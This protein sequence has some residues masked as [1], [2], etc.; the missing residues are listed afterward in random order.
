MTL[1]IGLLL[2]LLYAWPAQAGLLL[3]ASRVIYPADARERSLEIV[4][5][6]TYPVLLQT[7]VD[8]GQ[9]NGE[10]SLGDSPFVALPAVLRLE[11]LA[12]QTI[13]LLYN[14]QPLPDDRESLYWLNLLEIPPSSA[15]QAP[16]EHL[17]VNLQTQIKVL[18]RPQGLGSPEQVGQRQHVALAPAGNAL[19]WHN[20]TAH[21][22]TL[23][24][25]SLRT[26]HGLQTLP[27]TLLAPFTSTCIGL[28][29][30]A[31]SSS[32]VEM[33]LV[34]DRGAL[35]ELQPSLQPFSDTPNLAP[36]PLPAPIS[37][38]SP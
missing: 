5:T 7:W 33:R 16:G 25:V 28:A 10:S 15:P 32:H 21:Y 19:L 12:R 27:G 20:P 22:V 35:R 31:D 4:N 14:G 37:D 13:R 11:P 38:A 9:H 6:N 34:D 18:W 23:S 8:E 29:A 2:T 36:C 1:R 26:A 24:E 30:R 3:S 17:T